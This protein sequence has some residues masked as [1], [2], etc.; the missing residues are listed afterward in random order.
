M[1]KLEMKILVLWNQA[2]GSKLKYDY[3]NVYYSSIILILNK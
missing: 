1:F 3:K 2:E